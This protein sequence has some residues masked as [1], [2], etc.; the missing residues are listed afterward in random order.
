MPTL[1]GFILHSPFNASRSCR[2]LKVSFSILHYSLFIIHYSLFFF[3]L[4]I[5]H[6]PFSIIHFPL[7]IIHYPLSIIHYPLSII[8]YTF[9]ILHYSFSIIHSSLF[10]HHRHKSFLLALLCAQGEYVV[11]GTGSAILAFES[12]IPTYG[13]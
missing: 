9:S 4:S 3:P 1:E 12:S 8:H 5:I 2:R 7:F 10:P 6:F 13:R 11:I